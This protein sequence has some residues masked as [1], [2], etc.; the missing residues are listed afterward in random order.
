MSK[1]CGI[2]ALLDSG[3]N[4]VVGVVVDQSRLAWMRLRDTDSSK[5]VMLRSHFSCYFLYKAVLAQARK[6]TDI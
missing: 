4:P 1:G 5:G 2:P 6:F 3:G